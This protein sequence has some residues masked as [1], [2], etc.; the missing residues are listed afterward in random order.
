MSQ[1]YTLFYLFVLNTVPHRSTFSCP[2]DHYHYWYNHHYHEYHTPAA[3]I[4]ATPAPAAA[5][6]SVGGANKTVWDQFH[7]STP[8]PLHPSMVPLTHPSGTFP[9]G[10]GFPEHLIQVSV[11][12]RC[13]VAAGPTS[14]WGRRAVSS[15][16]MTWYGFDS[17]QLHTSHWWPWCLTQYSFVLITQDLC[18]LLKKKKDN[19]KLS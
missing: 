6:L 5:C 3:T 1:E 4:M 17:S 9:K 10:S 7:V 8:Y 19:M 13:K 14:S 12:H 11:Y 18:G 15:Q 16:V 2:Y